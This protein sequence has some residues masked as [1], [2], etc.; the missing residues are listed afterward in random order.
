MR[1]DRREFLASVGGGCAGMMLATGCAPSGSGQ[2]DPGW[3]PG[4]EVLQNSSCLICPARCGIRAR[5]VDG[6]LVRIAGN[7]LHPLS[8][9]GLCPRGPAAVQMLYH[10]ERLRAP[11]VRA[12]ARAGAWRDITADAA[13]ELV[14]RRLAELRS[15][16]RPERVAALCGYCSGSMEALWRQFM[17]AYGS[18][19]L[20]SDG[21]DDGTAAIA[22][23]MH[24]IPRNPSYDFDRA[25]LVLSFGA[26][27]FEAWWAPTQAFAALR[28]TRDSV[29]RPRFIQVDTR[30][31][32][33]A[34]WS[35]EWIAVRPRTH[36]VLA[37]GIAY[38]L[39]R[40]ELVDSDFL[41]R[42]VDGYEDW[43]D[44]GGTRH[45][46]YRAAVLRH[47]RTEEVSQITGV[48]VER[49][50]ATAKTFADSAPA[51][52]VCGSDVTY[53][54]DGLLAG[55]AVHSLN[56]LV[57]SINRPGGVLYRDDPPLAPLATP[58]L[59]ATAR[60]GMAHRPLAAAAPLGAATA[61]SLAEALVAGDAP[62]VDVLFLYY[63][64]PLASPDAETWA[65]ALDRIPLVVSFTPFP[66]ETSGL[67]DLIVPDL[68]AQERWQDA[69]APA[70]HPYLTWGLTQPLVEP[71]AHTMDTANFLL[72]L[73]RR[74]GGSVARSLPY[75][76][77]R[78]L[79]KARA[80]GLFEA[81]R[82]MPFG[83]AFETQ[84]QAQM[85]ERGWWLPGTSDFESFWRELV[86]RGGWVDPFHDHTN[87]AGLS[88]AP[89]GRVQLLPARLSELLRQSG[90]RL[91]PYL[92]PVGAR[93]PPGEFPLWLNVY[94]VSTLAS[95]TLG[96][97]RWLAE[98]PTPLLDTHDEPWIEVN[99]ATARALGLGDG[100]RAR[101]I[102]P[103]GQYAAAVRLSPGT[104]PDVVCAPYGPPHRDAR[105]ANPL[106][107]MDRTTDPLTGLAS[108]CTTFVRLEPA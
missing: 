26:P 59:D 52:V 2:P 75:P 99:P 16:G 87:P 100:D 36:A 9:G 3:A 63:A 47:Y 89:N 71:L 6:R 60:A 54:P 108:W 88:R 72:A 48:P 55:M 104:A 86:E 68:L 8:R 93:Q 67:A 1:L 44:A 97:T 33:T 12:T 41:A 19:N 85:E 32:R 34:A 27:L 98:R 69:P 77:F 46:G 39:I 61:R 64:N 80:R 49:I 21:Y 96:L 5:V 79:L 56:V 106:Q 91:A 40:E 57:G 18:P 23:V 81:R 82:G 29:G 53:S 95:G 65:A 78:E 10:P 22:T 84:H 73:A 35:D 92:F 51:L 7:P 101:V 37:L 15:A 38:V 105:A 43:T 90:S 102:S 45:E 28:P 66:D 94:R 76:D 24:A 30:F 42:H 11:R 62:P 20:V 4:V 103:R 17:L 50:V 74:L 14:A 83:D 25:R 70:S 107:L 58:Q 31:S 13:L